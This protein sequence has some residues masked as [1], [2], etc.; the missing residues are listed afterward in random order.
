MSFVYFV[1]AAEW[2]AVYLILQAG[3][4]ALTED[5]HLLADKAVPVPLP[6]KMSANILKYG[7]LRIT[8]D[9]A[10]DR[11]AAIL[12]VAPNGENYWTMPD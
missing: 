3:I 9:Y 1:Q 7:H 5:G 8:S 4:R 11:V 10:V 12:A 2:V 6:C